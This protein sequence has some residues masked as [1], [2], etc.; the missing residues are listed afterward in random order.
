MATVC[1]GEPE[2]AEQHQRRVELWLG[3]KRTDAIVVYQQVLGLKA[4]AISLQLRDT[5]PNSY[6]APDA[7]PH[8]P[9][10]LQY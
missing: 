7:T 3:D 4:D 10:N 8:D 1:S 6:S 2:I 5:L 9:I